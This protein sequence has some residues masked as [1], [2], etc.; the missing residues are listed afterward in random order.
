MQKKKLL[1]LSI[2]VVFGISFLPLISARSFQYADLYIRVEDKET[3]A[4]LND[5]SVT[6]DIGYKTMTLETS[7]SGYVHFKFVIMSNP[8]PVEVYLE[9][10]GYHSLGLGF[11]VQAGYNHK[12]IEMTPK[13]TQLFS[14]IYPSNERYNGNDAARH[15][16]DPD[17]LAFAHSVLNWGKMVKGHTNAFTDKAV[18]IQAIEDFCKDIL[19]DEYLRGAPI[20]S[21]SEIVD[22]IQVQ[23]T[24]FTFSQDIVC[25]SMAA[26]ISGMARSIGI[27]SEMVCIQDTNGNRDHMVAI[28]HLSPTDFYLMDASYGYYDEDWDLSTPSFMQA[29]FG[30]NSGDYLHPWRF[31]AIWEISDWEINYMGSHTGIY[32]YNGFM[33]YYHN[34]PPMQLESYPNHFNIVTENPPR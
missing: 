27:D 23:G 7:A 33:W 4:V 25:Y 12:V 31:H 32:Y 10:E 16:D 34:I 20:Y 18:A 29:Y 3:G 5:V 1:Y 30:G 21:D 19:E 15:P 17:V 22:A 24:T 14:Y 11:Y 6:L 8:S 26:L 13:Y 28:L 2:L 9:K